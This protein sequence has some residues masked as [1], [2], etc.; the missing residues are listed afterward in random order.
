MR[1]IAVF[2]LAF[3]LTGCAATAPTQQVSVTVHGTGVPLELHWYRNS[4]ERRALY[5][6]VYAVGGQS[7]QALAKGLPDNSWGVIMDIDETILDNSEYQ[8]RLST[9]GQDFSNATWAAWVHDRRAVALPG[10]AAFIHAVRSDD[11]GRVVLVSNRSLADCPD[12]EAN[13]HAQGIEY[14]AILCAPNG[15]DGKPVSDKNPRF[16]LVRSG[17]VESLGKLNVLAYFGDNIQDFPNLTQ[18]NPG[19]ASHFGKDYFVLPNPM[20]GSWVGNVYR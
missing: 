11:H 13:L 5:E 10:A 7:V 15:A 9:T 4:A 6:E 2:G 14:D 17:G 1:S 8:A 20:Y 18:A 3:V 12:T 19:D 16:A